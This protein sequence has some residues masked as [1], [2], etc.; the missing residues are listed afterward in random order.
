MLIPRNTKEFKAVRDIVEEVNENPR[1]KRSIKVYVVRPGQSL[2]H[3]VDVSKLKE[4]RDVIYN[5]TFDSVVES[6]RNQN[7]KLHRSE[8][9]KGLY[10]FHTTSDDRWD[11][12]PFMLSKS[13]MKKIPLTT[14]GRA[15][16]DGPDRAG[17][18]LGSHYR[19]ER[20]RERERS[21]R[22]VYV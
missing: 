20:E 15:G 11:R 7:Y 3:R 12:N 22:N 5:L 17:G 4:D 19:P 9:I 18:G 21:S 2:V 1:K 6:L 10:Y 8:E 16:E 13:A 14:A